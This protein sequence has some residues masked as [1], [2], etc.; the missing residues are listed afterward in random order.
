[1]VNYWLCITNLDNWQVIKK[2]SIWGVSERHKGQLSKAEIGDILLFYT[3]SEVIE[4]VQHGSA[5]VGIYKVASEPYYDI[6]QIFSGIGSWTL[7][8]KFPY[9]IKVEPIEIFEKPLPFK[10]LVDKLEFI[11][12]VKRW[13][14]HIKGR[15]MR[16][17]PKKDFET[18]K[19]SA[20]Q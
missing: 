19:K 11:T 20:Q 3:V 1:M 6:D 9:R 2:M 4:N 18:I 10:P 12:N 8:E 16:K 5:I 7:G 13:S 15:A 14:L 17:I